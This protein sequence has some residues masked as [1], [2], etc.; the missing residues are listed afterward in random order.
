MNLK[1]TLVL[2]VLVAAGGVLFLSADAL[3]PLFSSRTNTQTTEQTATPSTDSKEVRLLDGVS[4]E[5]ITRITLQQ[6][7]RQVVLERQPGGKWL[8][9]GN[10]PAREPEVEDLVQQLLT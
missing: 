9:P 3:A 10:W 6:A 2:L 1:T 8:L 4:A 5:A 7:D